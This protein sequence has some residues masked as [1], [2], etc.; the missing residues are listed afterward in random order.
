LPGVTESV[1]LGFYG[2]AISVKFEA[3]K[4]PLSVPMLTMVWMARMVGRCIALRV[5]F[6]AEC[7]QGQTALFAAD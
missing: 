6:G 7:E 5:L 4:I 1:S 3:R 2:Q